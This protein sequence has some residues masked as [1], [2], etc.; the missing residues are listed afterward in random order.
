MAGFTERMMGAATLDVRI[1]EEVEHDQNATGQAAGVVALVAVAGAIGSIGLGGF[2]IFGALLS[3]FVGWY[4]W[5]AV[6]LVVGTKIFE[7]TADMGEMLR[8]LAF[9]QSPGVLMVLGFLPIVGWFVRPVVGIW[10]LVCGIVAVRQALDFTTGKAIG[11]VLIGWIF[12]VVIG[13]LL[14]GLRGLFGLS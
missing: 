4:I 7:G 2:G 3:A 8:T 13:F 12:Y 1:Y 10:M 14:L 11:T 6:T 5:A 9:A